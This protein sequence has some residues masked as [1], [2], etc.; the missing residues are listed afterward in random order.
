MP[1]DSGIVH[2]HPV[3]ARHDL[4]DVHLEHVARLGTFDID[5]PGQRMGAAAR[6]LLVRV[7]PQKLA[8][9]EIGRAHV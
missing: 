2:V 9:F 7:D 6:N 4:V 1:G 3:G 8:A 5:R